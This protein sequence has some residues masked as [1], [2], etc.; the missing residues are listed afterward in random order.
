MKRNVTILLFAAFALIQIS[1]PLSIIVKREKILT[2][3]ELFKFK[4]K[5]TMKQSTY[6]KIAR[7]AK[8][9]LSRRGYGI[10]K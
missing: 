2:Q 1:I 8:Y 6:Q 5:P 7:S 10:S 4:T 3:G 9:R